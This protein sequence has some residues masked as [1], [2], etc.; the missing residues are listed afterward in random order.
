MENIHTNLFQAALSQREQRLIWQQAPK[1]PE[2]PQGAPKKPEAKKEE[3]LIEKA[4]KAFNDMGNKAG[5]L[6]EEV[7]KAK[8]PEGVKTVIGAVQEVSRLPADVQRLMKDVLASNNEKELNDTFERLQNDDVVNGYIMN[9]TPEAQTIASA[10]SLS[11]ETRFKKAVKIEGGK[12]VL[13]AVPQAAPKQAPVAG[14]KENPDAVFASLEKATTDQVL[15]A[16]TPEELEKALQE[17]NGNGQVMD[18]CKTPGNADKIAKSFNEKFQKAGSKLQVKVEGGMLVVDKT[19]PA[20]AKVEAKEKNSLMQ[21]ARDFVE[22][23]KFIC[24]ELGVSTQDLLKNKPQGLTAANAPTPVLGKAVDA[25]QAE[26]DKL[27]AGDQKLLKLTIEQGQTVQAKL[28][29][30]EKELSKLKAEMEKAV[31]ADKKVEEAVRDTKEQARKRGVRVGVEKSPDSRTIIVKAAEGDDR[32]M[33]FLNA[34]RNQLPSSAVTV[35]GNG[36]SMQIVVN[37]TILAMPGSHVSLNSQTVGEGAAAQASSTQQER[38]SVDTRT[39]PASA[40]R[41][42]FRGTNTGPVKQRGSLNG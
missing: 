22:M 31:K 42:P 41:T 29:K 10:I 11:V 39:Q 17:F 27:K 25:K 20:P 12:L 36:R 23:I 32:A 14:P 16:K 30:A 21:W 15:K 38:T 9:N 33:E 6:L 8:V 26:V 2:K 40:P 34:T 1:G 13:K 19:P 35:S 24:K 5:K 3:T 7:K 4:E 37:N 18:V 28:Q